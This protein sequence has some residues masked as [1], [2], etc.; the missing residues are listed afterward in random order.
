MLWRFSKGGQQ[1]G[2]RNLST[3]SYKLSLQHKPISLHEAVKK[4]ITTVAKGAGFQDV[5]EMT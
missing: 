3:H 2:S 1:Y 5:S 4:E